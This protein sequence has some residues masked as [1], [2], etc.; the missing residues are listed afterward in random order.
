MKTKRK[1]TPSQQLYWS[2][3]PVIS[4]R[5]PLDLYEP[6]DRLKGSR[7]WADLVKELLLSEQER[8]K[9]ARARAEK[10]LRLTYE[11]FK[12][13][14]RHPAPIELAQRRIDEGGPYRCPACRAG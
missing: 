2:Q 13:G 3:H 9:Q 1:G 12:C 7:S 10:A 6:L 5:L 8:D 11:C 14:K 4:F